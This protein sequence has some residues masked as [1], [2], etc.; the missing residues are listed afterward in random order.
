MPNSASY[1]YSH[2]AGPVVHMVGLATELTL[3]ALLKG[4]G[5][6]E[7]SVRKLGHNTYDAYLA[8]KIY[9]DE[10]KFLQL[11]FSNTEHLRLPK[12]IEERIV[13]RSGSSDATT[14]W[15]VFFNHLRILDQTYDRPYLTRYI[16]SGSIV[17]PDA[18][19]LL[20][21]SKI[22]ISAMMEKL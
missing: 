15:R 7:N 14:E 22:L 20:A 1:D 10:V 21:G 4:A 6:P 2:Y 17:L 16:K 18:Y 9:F 5:E 3:K 13:E 8:A 19:I 12:E 11:V